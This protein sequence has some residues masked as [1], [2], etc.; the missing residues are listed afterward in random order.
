M[1]ARTEQYAIAI[2]NDNLQASRGAD[3]PCYVPRAVGAFAAHRRT[4]VLALAVGSLAASTAAGCGG[5]Q[6]QDASAPHGNFRVAVDEATF[7]ADQQLAR[8]SVMTIRVH[9]PSR[10]TIPNINV[11]L[12]CGPGLR[13][14][15]LTLSQTPGVADPRRPQFVVNTIPTRGARHA[16]P[17][18]PAAIERTS[19]MTDTYPL[20][21]LSPGASATFQWNVTAVVAGPY[22]IC[23]HVNADL[24]G[25]ARP[26]R[27]IG[28]LPLQGSFVGIVSN[29]APRTCIGPND[30]SVTTNCR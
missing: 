21:P 5:G 16:P 10:R 24:Y 18:D 6:Q 22:R 27:T 25:D 20:G 14:S 13:G 1:P 9:N 4:T 29:A 3:A 19:A 23:Y 12:K 8:D 2:P 7:P 17:L 30:T 28:S 26:V 11:T 15:F